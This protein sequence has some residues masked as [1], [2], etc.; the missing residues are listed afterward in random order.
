MAL[1][2]A[3]E[4]RV[5]PTISK[6]MQFCFSFDPKGRR[7]VFNTLKITGIATIA[8]ALLFALFLVVKGKRPRDERG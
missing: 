1:L 6:V 2:E 5:G 4:G 3:S 7:Y 8:F